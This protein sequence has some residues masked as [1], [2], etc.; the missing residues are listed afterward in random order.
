MCGRFTRTKTIQEYAEHYKAEGIDANPG[1]VYVFR[2]PRMQEINI[3]LYCPQN[4]HKP[5]K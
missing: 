3:Q 5:D 4:A 1:T 2:M